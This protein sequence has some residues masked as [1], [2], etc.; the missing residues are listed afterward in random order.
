MPEQPTLKFQAVT[1]LPERERKTEQ[2]K[3]GRTSIYD[4]LVQEL[5]NHTGQWYEIECGNDRQAY[6]RA[7]ALRARHGMEAHARKS[8][9]Y[10]RH[11]PD[12]AT[13]DETPPF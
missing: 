11:M 2:L 1:E 6:S 8:Y 13:P 3:A 4:G 5:K 7:Q 10:V 12:D 9:V